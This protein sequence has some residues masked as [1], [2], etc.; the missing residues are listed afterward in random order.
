MSMMS[1]T[2][3]EVVQLS[4]GKPQPMMFQ[5][6]IVE[7]AFRKQKVNGSVFLSSLNFDGDLQADQKNHG[8]QDKAVL[9]YNEE[10]Y[11][12]WANRLGIELKPS[13][14]GENI[15]I[16]GLDEET[17]CIGDTFE[18][19]DCIIQVSQPRKPCFK[20]AASLGVKTLPALLE[21]TGFTGFYFRVLK[22]GW[23]TENPRL[24][25][26]EQGTGGVS[27]A[28][29]NRVMYSKPLNLEALKR[30]VGLLDLADKLKSSFLTKLE[31]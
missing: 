15:T 22:E 10:H 24:T 3:Y 1:K 14:F 6:R 11:T 21:E 23:V 16:R 9:G 20:V 5:K 19:D 13:A 18:L 30:F 2:T 29:I 31:K 26:I 27:I 25:L 4:V 8:G 12:Y 28:D 7:T 17:L